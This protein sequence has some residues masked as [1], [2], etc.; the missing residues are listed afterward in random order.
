VLTADS[1]LQNA[2]ALSERGIPLAQ[3]L[4]HATQ[5]TLDAAG[6]L[7]ARWAREWASYLAARPFHANAGLDRCFLAI[8]GEG[9]LPIETE[10]ALL[11]RARVLAGESPSAAVDG[12]ILDVD[13]RA[14][15]T[16]LFLRWCTLAHG[17][18]RPEEVVP[19]LPRG[20]PAVAHPRAA[21]AG[22]AR[23]VASRVEYVADLEKWGEPDRWQ[24]PFETLAQG[25]GD[26]E[27]MSLVVWSGATPLGL[28]EGRLVIGTLDGEGHAW[29]EFPEVGL[30]AE[31]TA[32]SVGWLRARPAS[33]EPWL[34]A[35]AD[36]RCEIANA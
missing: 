30:Y 28:P 32:G 2:L 4:R 1:L 6:R 20:R 19:F 18:Y 3:A 34:H 13:H 35:Y 7:G 8:F 10:F 16:I 27:D 14:T 11:V 5:G 9:K 26:C 15:T 23:W 33:Y 24:S 29:V 21:L 25:S 12:A 36:G 17:L 22:L 31:A